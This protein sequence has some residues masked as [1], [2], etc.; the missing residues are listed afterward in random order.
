MADFR[1]FV[2]NR[3]GRTAIYLK[4]GFEAEQMLEDG[5]ES[6]MV[7]AIFI[8]TINTINI[9]I[10]RPPDTKLPVFSQIIGS[11]ETLLSK[12]KIPEPSILVTGDFNFPFVKW[13]RGPQLIFILTKTKIII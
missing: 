1:V 11:V 13:T 5:E 3:R 4:D 8:E 12:M 6:C 7:V 10:Y 9:V 2:S